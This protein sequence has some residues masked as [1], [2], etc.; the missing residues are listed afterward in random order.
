LAADE[1]GT[2][3]TPAP[4]VLDDTVPAVVNAR[5]V[6]APDTPPIAM[7]DTGVDGTVPELAGRLVSPFDA[8][9][10]SM[11]G[12]DFDGHGTEVAGIAAGAPGLVQGVSPTS[13]VMPVRIFNRYGDSSTQA[14]LTGIRWAID[15]GAS[16]I[17]ISAVAPLKDVSTKDVA[18]V[19]RAIGEA[20][21]TGVLVVAAVGNEGEDQAGFPSSLPHV[22]AVGGSDTFG[23]RATFSDTGPWVDLVSP[24]ASLQAPTALDLCPSGYGVAN[25]TSFAAPAVAGAAALLAKLRPELNVEQRFSVL[26]SSARDVSL[27][28]RDDETGFGVLDVQAAVSAPAPLASGPSPEVD[29]DPYFVRG[30]FASSHPTLLS[31]S[32]TA[33]LSG[34]VSPAKDPSDVYPVR[35]RKGERFVAGATVKTLK[36]V[37]SLI[38]LGLWRP[39]V[40]DFDVSNEAAKQRVVSTGGFATDPRLTTR[41]TRTGTYYLSVEAPDAVDPDDPQAA[42]PVSQP[43]QL[44]LTRQTLTVKKRAVKKKPVRKKAKK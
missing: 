44:T 23:V 1:A 3:C 40:G 43:Y 39:G 11:D 38:E 7:L 35:L 18:A 30:P 17:N 22:V 16:V 41:V 4:A 29:D 27:A 25:G 12:S 24:A 5:S 8:L 28:G 2:F 10:G 32:R 20:F 37:D 26:R 14:L 36:G 31:K 21:S 19:T 6:S 9:G 15:H 33:K 34:D 13:P 42:I